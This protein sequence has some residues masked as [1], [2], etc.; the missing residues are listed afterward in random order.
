MVGMPTL[1]MGRSLTLADFETIRDVDDGHRYEL[2][3][4]AL[5][6]TPSPAARHQRIVPVLWQVLRESAP[7]GY[8]V[9][10]APLDVA[11]GPDTVVQPDVLVAR[12]EIVTEDGVDGVPALAVEVLSPS[13][14][15]FDLGAKKLCYEQAGCPA[16][17]VIDP[18]MLWLRAWELRGG[19]YQLVAHVTGAETARLDLPWPIPITPSAL[20]R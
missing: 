14:R 7:A 4:G 18:D 3:D 17:W 13:T 20:G 1:P 15:S 10:V 19:A 2:L 5:L 9:F 11:L 12:S 16:Y 6:V 8:E